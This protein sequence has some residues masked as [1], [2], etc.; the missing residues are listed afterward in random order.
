MESGNMAQITTNRGLGALAITALACLVLTGMARAQ[1]GVNG[2][3]SSVFDSS[4]N[5]ETT[6]VE[7][8]AGHYSTVARR[9]DG[10]VVA[11]GRND[12]GGCNAPVL[13]GGLTYVEVA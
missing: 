12:F 2:W 9:S 3:G 4:W 5:S 10:S 7:V 11:W 6:F 13:P 1:S 8:Q